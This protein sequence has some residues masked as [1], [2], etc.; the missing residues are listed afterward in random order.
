MAKSSARKTSSGTAAR[1]DLET[2]PR[3]NCRTRGFV[4]CLT[5][6][7]S[8]LQLAFTA[9]ATSSKRL[10]SSCNFAKSLSC[11]A[12]SIILVASNAAVFL[13]HGTGFSTPRARKSSP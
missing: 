13:V 7:P 5:F 4:F 10:N 6:V 8:G 9:T 3:W 12:A 11:L 2:E 1:D